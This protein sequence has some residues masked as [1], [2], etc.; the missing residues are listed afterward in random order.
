MAINIRGVINDV[1]S[2]RRGLALESTFIRRLEKIMH[3]VKVLCG[4]YLVG[5]E[6]RG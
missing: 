3:L 5:F 1:G 4:E 2:V 6:N